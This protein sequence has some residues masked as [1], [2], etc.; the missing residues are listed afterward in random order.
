MPPPVRSPER[1][2]AVSA[3]APRP[4]GIPDHT[5]SAAKR[6][7]SATWAPVSANVM[8]LRQPPWRLAVTL[9]VDGGGSPRTPRDAHPVGPVRGERN[10]VEPG[11]GVGAQ[12]AR[13]ADLVEELCGHG[14]HRHRAARPRVLGDHRGPVRMHLGQREAD[15][16]PVRHL[17][18]EGVVAA[19]ALGAALDHVAGHH[20][21]GDGVEI[22]VRPAEG[23]Q[24]RTDDEGGVGHAAR[25]DHLRAGL[26]ARRRSGA[27]GGRRWP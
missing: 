18:E 9:R 25:D 15:P 20:C 17:L 27:P 16:F 14:P 24:G 11:H 7:F 10:G 23:V 5:A 13:A 6:A 21:P 3:N 12:V 19:A 2:S 22:V 1:S 4:P 26:R 8:E